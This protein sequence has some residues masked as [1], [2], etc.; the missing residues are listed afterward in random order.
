MLDAFRECVE[1]CELRA[2]DRGEEGIEPPL[3]LFSGPAR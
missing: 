3:G 2:V 1:W